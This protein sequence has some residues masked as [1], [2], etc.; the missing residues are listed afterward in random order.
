MQGLSSDYAV[1]FVTQ[2]YRVC[3]Q[4]EPDATGLQHYLAELK[5]GRWPHELVASLLESEEFS[6]LW[7]R[8]LSPP[9]EGPD[10]D[11][12]LGE[13]RQPSDAAPPEPGASADCPET[14]PPRRAPH[15][16]A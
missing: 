6:S 15:D 11:A 1:E 10:P 9:S 7:R 12:V 5:A 13:S 4:R 2:L 16:S 8:K 14:N 3:L